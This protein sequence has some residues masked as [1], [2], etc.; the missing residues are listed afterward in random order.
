MLETV[1][2]KD[3][4]I[5][6]HAAESCDDHLADLQR[7]CAHPYLELVMGD[8]FRPKAFVATV[9]RSLIGSSAAMCAEVSGP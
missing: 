9:S 1:S 7:E 2:L 4:A 5:W 8:D 3:C 6:K